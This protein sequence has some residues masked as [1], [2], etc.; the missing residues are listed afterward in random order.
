MLITHTYT[1]EVIMSKTPYEIRLDLLCLAKDSLFQVYTNTRSSKEQEWYGKREVD[2][3]T[4]YPEM[5]KA[6]TTEEIIAQ[7]TELNKFVS[8]GG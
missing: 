2:P 5:P 1:Q 3:T 6:P 7:A 8:A 4:P